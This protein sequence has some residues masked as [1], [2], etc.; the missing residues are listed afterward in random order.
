M[1]A[2]FGQIDPAAF[3]IALIAL[4]VATEQWLEPL[5]RNYCNRRTVA[6]N[7]ALGLLFG[8][9]FNTSIRYIPAPPG[10]W[11]NLFE[12]ALCECDMISFV[13]LLPWYD[14]Y[15]FSLLNI[16]YSSGS[17]TIFAFV[18]ILTKVGKAG[19]QFILKYE[20]ALR[21]HKLIKYKPRPYGEYGMGASSPGDIEKCLIADIWQALENGTS[22]ET[23]EANRILRALGDSGHIDMLGPLFIYRLLQDD[24]S[25]SAIL[26]D[27]A[28]NSGGGV[29]TSCGIIPIEIIEIG[30]ELMVRT[31]GLVNH[32]RFMLPSIDMTKLDD[33]CWAT[34]ARH[35]LRN[36]VLPTGRDSLL[37]TVSRIH[38]W[39][40]DGNRPWC[41]CKQ[42]ECAIVRSTASLVFDDHSQ[43][44]S[45]CGHT[46]C[47]YIST[48]ESVAYSKAIKANFSV[49]E[50]Q[51]HRFNDLFIANNNK[52][53]LF[54]A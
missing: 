36:N 52:K 51:P 28:W 12:E 48:S 47:F 16:A 17:S 38:N 10:R 19:W 25:L 40:K 15:W 26:E 44:R 21:T 45:L 29:T 30:D 54:I 22:W 39:S 11:N 6:F 33:W 49:I 5:R 9:T 24:I 14:L 43:T 27:A 31:V 20:D 13:R 37:V 18:T 8:T 50:I 46:N 41:R 34:V 4:F 53:K 1:T 3:F 32:E 2:I 23:L 35:S 7:Q 42:D